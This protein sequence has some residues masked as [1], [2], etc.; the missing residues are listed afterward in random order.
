[1]QMTLSKMKRGGAWQ[2]EKEKERDAREKLN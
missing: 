1:M 2:E